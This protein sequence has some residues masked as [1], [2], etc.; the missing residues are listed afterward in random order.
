[1]SGNPAKKE[2]QQG[3]PGKKGQQKGGQ[4]QESKSG[5]GGGKNQSQ[6][7]SKGKQAEGSEDVK[8][9]QK[10]QAIILADS[11]SK[12]F[13]PVTLECPKVLLPL[14]NVPMLD[15]TIEF[16]SQN[17]VE[18]VFVFCVWH[19]DKVEQYLKQSKWNDLLSI[20]CISSPGCCSAGDALREMD[21]LSIIR[22][23]P[24]VL[25]SGD[26]I[27]NLNLKK[28][29]AYHKKKRSEDPNNIMTLVLKKVQK[30]AGVKPILDDLVV[31]IN[32]HS[33]QLVFFDDSV[34][35]QGIQI[36]LELM[37]YAA[38]LTFST[39]YLDCNVDICSPELILQFSD[40]FDYQVIR[41]STDV[42]L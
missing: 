4:P 24:F 14:V 31:G 35:K 28:A 30:V 15:Y 2:K 34:H 37:R 39:E 9:E 23:D 29:I 20:Q 32:K 8:R 36:P 16:L 12:T 38:D 7:A 3:G 33:S 42:I 27:S 40:N 10:L 26:V 21:K 18:E 25:I 19:A 22:S 11:F 41:L 13:R 1:M 6:Q 17:G 5:K